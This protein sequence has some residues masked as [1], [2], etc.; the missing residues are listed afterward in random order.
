MAFHALKCP[1]CGGPLPGRAWRAVVTC[2]YCGSAFASDGAIVRAAEFR[3]ALAA[4]E[5]QGAGNADARLCGVP[6]R[7]LGHLGSGTRCDVLLAARASPLTERV[8]IKALR[9][10][11]PGGLD[12]A[13][14]AICAL[15]ESEA[16]GADVFTAR[17]PQPVARGKLE[18]PAGGREAL[19]VRHASGFVHTLED[20]SRAYPRGVD[21]RHAV[22]IWRRTLELLGFV[23][24][25][26]WSHGALEPA[27]VLV[28]ARDHGV[29]FAGWSAASQLSA[30]PQS[31]RRDLAL[32]AR[33]AA[34]VLAGAAPP[35]P[36][37]ILMRPFLDGGARALPTEDAWE[38]AERVAEA[39]GQAFGPPKY[40]ELSMPEVVAVEPRCGS[41][42]R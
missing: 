32:S 26:G 39:A 2:S 37:A 41:K 17:L 8:V 40:V 21:P 13:W 9:A 15:Q 1:S 36:L 11:D 38:L 34:S 31:R 19:A 5:E 20:V 18:G 23:H 27:H 3:R 6:Y 33:C 42:E 12:R 14:E 4:M 10:G 25:S 30:A 22:W 24:A 29:A 35:Q 16:Q 28:H 7:V